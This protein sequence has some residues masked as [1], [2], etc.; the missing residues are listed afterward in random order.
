[1]PTTPLFGI[2]PSANG[3]FPCF[4]FPG[5]RL[6]ISASYR[7]LTT[8]PY[9]VTQEK[10]AKTPTRSDERPAAMKAPASGRVGKFDP[11]SYA[12]HPPVSL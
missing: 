2:D 12:E 1:M 4:V 7:L 5:W 10:R 6:S 3:F 8:N 9:A 11:V